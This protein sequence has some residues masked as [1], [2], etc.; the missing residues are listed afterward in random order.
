VFT[1]AMIRRNSISIPQTSVTF[2]ETIPEANHL[3]ARMLF[4]KVEGR[5]KGKKLMMTT[6]Q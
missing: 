3:L 6:N 5:D 2:Y 1:A 4:V